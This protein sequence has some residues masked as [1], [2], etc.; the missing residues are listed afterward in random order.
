MKSFALLLFVPAFASAVVNWP[1]DQIAM[2]P[3]VT[4]AVGT[5]P[6]SL[7]VGLGDFGANHSSVLSLPYWFDVSASSTFN[8]TG[9]GFHE[10]KQVFELNGTDDVSFGNENRTFL[11]KPL[12][13]SLDKGELGWNVP[14]DGSPSFV[15][16]VL[17]ELEEE[18][19]V[20]S[21]DKP[22]YQYFYPGLIT[23]GGRPADRCGN[24]WTYVPTI[25]ITRP[26]DQWSLSV[27]E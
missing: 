21:F 20:F 12:L 22:V 5:P 14:T 1:W 27:D 15:Q 11:I 16:S 10:E 13:K 2:E 19:V 9:R 25:P 7:R 17:K 6:Q 23:L 24:H 26:E 18:V 4:M 8:V 3:Q